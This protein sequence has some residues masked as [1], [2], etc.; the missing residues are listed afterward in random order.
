MKRRGAKVKLKLDKLLSLITGARGR[1]S[2]R[3]EVD[4]HLPLKLLQVYIKNSMTISLIAK[5]ICVCTNCC[6]KNFG[7]SS[8]QLHT[9]VRHHP[10]QESSYM[11]AYSHSYCVHCHRQD[12]HY[13]CAVTKKYYNFIVKEGRCTNVRLPP[14]FLRSKA[15]STCFIKL[16]CRCNSIAV[17]DPD[18]T[19]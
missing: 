12:N 18:M 1:H 13:R 19:T 6:I 8:L 17:H 7:A 5:L 9:H 2:G 3:L 14:N 4:M 10:F 15:Y 16:I 11:P